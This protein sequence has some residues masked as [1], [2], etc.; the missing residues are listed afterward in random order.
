MHFT[1]KK[2][3]KKISTFHTKMRT[4]KHMKSTKMNEKFRRF[5][6][7]TNKEFFDF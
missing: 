5:I 3:V 2:R 6:I 1:K 7:N 4:L